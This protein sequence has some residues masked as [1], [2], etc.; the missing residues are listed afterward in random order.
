[1][2]VSK[3][4]VVFLT[5]YYYYNAV[6]ALRVVSK[7]DPGLGRG[8]MNKVKDPSQLSDSGFSQTDN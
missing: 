3:W 6:H 8:V 5:D 4:S 1:M 2:S 7:I